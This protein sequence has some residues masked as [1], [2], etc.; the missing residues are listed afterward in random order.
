[1]KEDLVLL[2]DEVMLLLLS[3][4]YKHNLG[5]QSKVFLFFIFYRFTKRISMQKTRYSIPSKRLS[6]PWALA[7][8]SRWSHSIPSPKVFVVQKN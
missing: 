7:T 5:R 8:T 2:A 1:M 3:E 6:G 4:V